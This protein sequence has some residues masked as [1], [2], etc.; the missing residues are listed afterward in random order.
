MAARH[1]PRNELKAGRPG[2]SAPLAVERNAHRHAVAALFASVN[3]PQDVG[4]A[5]FE[6]AALVD[7]LLLARWRANG[8]DRL[9]LA[10]LAVGGYGRQ[11]LYPCSDIDILILAADDSP[12]AEAIQRFLG[13]LWDL[14]LDLGHS[15]RTA[16]EC[17]DQADADVTVATALLERRVLTDDA[18]LAP[19]LDAL[20]RHRF[21]ASHFAKAKLFEQQQRHQRFQDTAYNLEPNI[22]ES[23]GGLRDAQMVIWL[24]RSLGFGTSFEAF[25]DAGDLTRS[26]HR[27]LTEAIEQLRFLRVRLHLLAGRREDRL[28]F[29]LQ[30][31]LADALAVRDAGGLRKS[32]LLM[33]RYYHAARRVKLFNDL[34][35]DTLTSERSALRT[36]LPGSQFARLDD[37]L[38]LADAGARLSAEDVLDAYRLLF[39]DR[40]FRSFTPGLRRAIARAVAELPPQ[41]FLSPAV[42]A[43]LLT[44]LRSGHGIYHALRDMNELGVLGRLIPPWDAIVGQMQHDLFHVY[45]VDQHILMVLRNMR[46]FTDPAHAHEYPLC[47]ELM[48]EF[49]EREVLYLACLFHDIAK[50]RGG[51]HSE[52]GMHDALAFCS[53]LGLSK[54]SAEFVAWL[55]AHH[56][57]MSTVAQK[58]DIT[59][60]AV[61]REFTQFCGNETRLVALY[62][63]T[64]ADIRG[65]SP[66]VWNSWKSRLLEQLFRSA[67]ALLRQGSDQP[68]DFDMLAD[69][70]VEARRLLALYAVDPERAEPLWQSLDSVYLQR[71][72]AD[73]IAWH[74]RN[75]FWRVKAS[76]PVVRTR[77]LSSGEGLQVM[78]YLRDAPN[79]FLRVMKVFARLGFSVLDARIHTSRLGY[80]LD[81]FTVVNPGSA[82]VAYRDV[83]QLLEHELAE[84]LSQQEG[85]PLPP[86]GRPS[87]QQRHQP[88]TPRIEITPDESGQRFTLEIVAADRAGLLAHAAEILARRAISIETARVNTL[89]ARAEDVFVISGGRL[90]EEATRIALE[91]E[92]AEAL[93]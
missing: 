80:A 40:E 89:G 50:G 93:A 69:R 11:E 26:E 16:T 15:V 60:P 46:R 59:D 38:D 2:V 39:G 78:V 5:L 12:P 62:L 51:D 64:V 45:T 48:Q 72:D 31:R 27:S 20:W 85:S 55:V 67:R 32:E 88:I 8:L 33:K 61:V 28:V 76:A 54:E 70:M 82:T 73:E 19:T 77:L 24:A 14:G 79:L 21:D 44:A 30:T 58:R 7:R 36:P 3:A 41:D 42:S 75:L 34:L 35:I 81:T 87:R 25:V 13:D 66:K 84:T 74:A 9:G 1:R 29:E 56:L 63:L 52:L 91:T 47:S 37:R 90:A 23:P 83:T 49:R 65:T 92:L 68:S 4:Q 6:H 43:R 71:H 57:R 17:M 10:L 53:E 22:K 18:G 86:L